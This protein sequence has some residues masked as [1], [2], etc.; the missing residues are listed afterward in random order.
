MFIMVLF[1]LVIGNLILSIDGTLENAG[2][3]YLGY[4]F[5]IKKIH[6]S[7]VSYFAIVAYRVLQYISAV[8]EPNCEA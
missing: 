1:M 3:H 5:V 6:S 4:L 7:S 8:T 2:I